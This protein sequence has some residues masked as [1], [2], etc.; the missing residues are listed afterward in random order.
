MEDSAGLNK[1]SH[2]SE[3]KVLNDIVSRGLIGVK[4]QSSNVPSLNID[5]VTR[6]IREPVK[7]VIGTN[8][9]RPSNPGYAYQNT[10]PYS[11][12]HIGS[13]VERVINTN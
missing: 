2:E 11:T 7:K 4:P 12:N 3:F 8:I 9:V 6:I 13:L 10:S 1:L 5:N